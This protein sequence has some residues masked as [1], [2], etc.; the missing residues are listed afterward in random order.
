MCIS[1][2]SVKLG[3]VLDQGT[4]E[5]EGRWV[6]LIEGQRKVGPMQ[7]GSTWRSLH[8]ERISVGI[9]ANGL[10]QDMVGFS[11]GEIHPLKYQAWN[12]THVS[13]VALYGRP[14]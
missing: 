2:V 12:Y 14:D 5:G 8:Q 7:L 6:R 11:P 10:G 13:P 9:M 4:L 1:H 3:L